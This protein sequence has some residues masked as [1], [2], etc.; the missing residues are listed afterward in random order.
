MSL[1]SRLAH[2]RTID[3]PRPYAPSIAICLVVC[4]MTTAWLVSSRSSEAAEGPLRWK[5]STGQKLR[6]EWTQRVET[7]TAIGDK[8]LR[9][10]VDTT[11][12][13]DWVVGPV[14]ES[15]RADITQSFRRIAVRMDLPPAAPLEFDSSSG[16][17][18]SGDLRPIADSLTPLIGPTWQATLSARGEIT[19]VAPSPELTAALEKVG[20]DGRLKGLFSGV[21]GAE[22]LRRSLVVLPEAPVKMGDAWEIPSE[23]ES[24]VGRVKVV[25]KYHHRGVEVVDGQSLDSIE[26]TGEMDWTPQTKGGLVKERRITEQKQTG[27][28]LFDSMAGRVVESRQTQSL[29]TESRVRDLLLDVRLKSTLG[30]KLF[31]VE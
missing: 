4:A 25:T 1:D 6:A 5:F 23:T 28:I 22:G 7:D 29:R 15:G 24:P 8:P 20:A 10:V 19:Q 27:S 13:Q 18:P 9:L 30:L 12:E 3:Q 11:F 16:K 2:A 26:S 17:R 14:D 31:A 21:T